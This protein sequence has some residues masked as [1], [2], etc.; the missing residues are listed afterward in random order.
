AFKFDEKS[1]QNVI[2]ALTKLKDGLPAAVEKC[3][4]HFPGV[5]RTISGYSGLQAAQDRLPDNN[6]RDAFAEDYLALANIW[7]ALSPDESLYPYIDDY[8]WL[9]EVYESVKSDSG[10]GALLWHSLGA[11]TIEL[12]HENV[13]VEA[14]R[15][16]LEILVMDSDVLSELLNLHDPN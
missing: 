11:K 4:A 7:E 3:L 14:I 1:M 2:T 6:K 15:D 5:D 8:R 13:H 12:I 9:S 16:D 10:H